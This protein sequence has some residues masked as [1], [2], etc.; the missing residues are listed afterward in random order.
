M[1][2]SAQL[3]RAGQESLALLVAK[4][5]ALVAVQ[6]AQDELLELLDRYDVRIQRDA[7]HVDGIAALCAGKKF[8]VVDF[9]GG[10]RILALLVNRFRRLRN[11]AAASRAGINPAVFLQFSVG[12]DDSTGIDAEKSRKL[13]H[14]RQCIPR[15]QM[16]VLYEMQQGIVKL[17]IQCIFFIFT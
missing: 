6:H 13:S 17:Y 8:R 4:G 3:I 7:A 1:P 15:A 12:T 14:R 5:M 10:N 9:E 16:S 2:G 11:V